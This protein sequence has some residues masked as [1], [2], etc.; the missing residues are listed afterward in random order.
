MTF[1]MIKWKKLAIGI[2]SVASTLAYSQQTVTLKQAIEFALQNKADALKSRLDITNADAKILEAKAGA[3]PKV[4]GNANITYNPIIQEIALGG[5]TFKMGQPWVA[6]AGV[7]LQQALFNQQVF[8]GLKAAKSTKEFYQ[9]NANLTEE[10]I[11]ERV[12]NAYFQVFTAQEQKNTLESSYSSTEK[13]RNVIKSLYDNGLSKK[14]DLDRTN[15]NLTNIETNIK[16]SNNGITQAEN[17]LK[18]YM[19]MPIETK[20]QL[21]QEDMAV[22]PHLLDETVNTDERTEV[23]V[24]LKN[25]ELLEYQKK[26]TIANYYPTVNLTANYNW[27]GLGEKFPLT[28]GSSKG[29]MWSDY[30][31]IGLGINIPIFNGFATKAKVQQNQIDIDKLEIDIKD[32]KLGLDQAYQNAKAQI[33]NSLATLESQKANVKLAED[34]LADTKSNYQYGLATL[35]DLL[36]AENSLVQAKNNYTTAILDYKIAEV[37]YYKSKGELKNYLK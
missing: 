18:F 1:K 22:T 33:E 23:K 12:S 16:Q 30:S 9:L 8:I 28:N 32:T 29:V 20:I 10:Q 3:L 34:V 31:A 27:Q 35:T 24:L 21:V 13:V 36:D 5:Q 25:K 11:I 19:G 17:A 6:V 26:A 2:F 14:I 15:V 4:T 7:Q 37:Q